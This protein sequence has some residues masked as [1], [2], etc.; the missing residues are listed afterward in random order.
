MII[1][2]IVINVLLDILINI[3]DLNAINVYSHVLIVIILLPVIN[4]WQDIIYL[5]ISVR[6]VKLLIVKYVNQ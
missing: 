4:V 5:I 6:S 1:M 2:I 3:Q